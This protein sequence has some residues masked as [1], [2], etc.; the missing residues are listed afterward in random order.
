MRSGYDELLPVIG[1][2]EAHDVVDQISYAHF[3]QTGQLLEPSDPSKI[4]ELIELGGFPGRLT[5]DDALRDAL[6]K[7]KYETVSRIL[8]SEHSMFPDNEDIILSRSV[9]YCITNE[10]QHDYYEIE[11][12]LSGQAYHLIDHSEIVVSD[13]DTIIVPPNVPHDLRVIGDGVVLNIGIRKST[14]HKVFRQILEDNLPLSQYFQRTLYDE[15]YRN[16]LVFHCKGD[17]FW[18][19]TVLRLYQQHSEKK[20][21]ANQIVKHLTQAGLYYIMQLYP[22]QQSIVHHSQLADRMNSIYRYI[23]LNHQEVSL[24]AVAKE[25]GLSVPY[26]SSLFRKYYGK[27]FSALLRSIRLHHARELLKDTTMR[28]VDICNHVGYS[29]ESHFIQIFKKEYGVTP[30]QYQINQK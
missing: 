21:Y 3:L 6:A 25:Y 28:I 1:S 23:N 2:L 12:V 11:C 4:E 10:H 22:P 8:F 27:T 30:K 24:A 13:G 19:E 16:S 14:F 9:R 18:R 15:R 17:V 7:G 26:L 5:E 20:P 29:E